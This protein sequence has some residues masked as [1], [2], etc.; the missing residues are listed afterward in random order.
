MIYVLLSVATS[1]VQYLYALSMVFLEASG[2]LTIG[3]AEEVAWPI[4]GTS[5]GRSRL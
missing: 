3:R 1:I 2:A 4:Q 5:R